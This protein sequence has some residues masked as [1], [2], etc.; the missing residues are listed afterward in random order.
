MKG[1]RSGLDHYKDARVTIMGLGS[2]GGGV[3]ATRFFHTLG[4][5]VT[6]TD[7]KGK[8]ALAPSLKQIEDL[9]VDFVL[10]R[11]VKRHFEDADMVV[12]NP[13]VPEDSPYVQA[14]R[15][16]GVRTESVLNFFLRCCPCRVIGVTGSNG[17][18]TTTVLL[19]EML[20]AAG[21]K[22]FVGGNL[23]GDILHWLFELKAEDLVVLEMSS[24]QLKALDPETPSPDTSVIT[25]L[26][27]NH[28]DRHGTM[29]DYYQSK[30]RIFGGQQPSRRVVIN[31]V[32][33]E[34]MKLIRTFSGEHL[35]FDAYRAQ[36][37]GLCVRDGRVNYRYK[38]LRGRLF[39]VN[40]LNLHGKFNLENAMAAAGAALL[41]GCSSLA[42]CR[43]VRSFAG[44]PHRLEYVGKWREIMVYNDSKSTNPASTLCAVDALP[45][46]LLVIVG[47]SDKELELEEM[48]DVLCRS[49][50]AVI[51][52][53]DVGN[54]VYR[55]MAERRGTDE[56]PLLLWA[57]PFA[58]A[59]DRALAM[60]SP[61]DHVLLSPGF[62]SFDQ[63]QSFEERGETF[64]ALVHAWGEK[65]EQGI[66]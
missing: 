27:P 21:L 66:K 13:A 64:H 24:F 46:P 9:D 14:A 8:R 63:F 52:Y 16:A 50:K 39:A 31:G 17:K 20:R 15:L 36:D 65:G 32:D 53:G 4:A 35:P 51:C 34:V 58:K 11:H 54:R 59:V 5:H 60:A 12:V 6:V 55:A 45:S 57:R 40:E 38:G 44:L 49:V 41:E 26:A 28:L 48:A 47:G 42:I 43:A 56:R 25:N 19:G 29:E 30:A 7:L 3:G 23:G 33:A 61:G 62:A 37:N 22:P 18:S 10:G 2:H 1:L